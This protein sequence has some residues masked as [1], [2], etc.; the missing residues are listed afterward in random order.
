LEECSTSIFRTE[1]RQQETDNNEAAEDGGDSHH[2]ENLKSIS[3]RLLHDV[4]LKMNRVK[5]ISKWL[6]K[7]SC[8][9]LKAILIEISKAVWAVLYTVDG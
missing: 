7:I 3:F 4:S 8:R 6:D 5:Q 1:E 9:W 2:I